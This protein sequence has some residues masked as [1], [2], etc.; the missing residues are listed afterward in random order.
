MVKG[1]VERGGSSRWEAAPS[2]GNSNS[3]PTD[4]ASVG[5]G[6]GKEKNFPR[7]WFPFTDGR[8]ENDN[9]SQNRWADPVLSFPEGDFHRGGQEKGAFYFKP[10]TTCPK[11]R[12]A[13]SSLGGAHLEETTKAQSS[14]TS[15]LLSKPVVVIAG[16]KNEVRD[17]KRFFVRKAKGKNF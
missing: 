2:M 13:D 16:P 9:L 15:S 6:S 12:Q 3:S 14:G 1:E 7:G 17:S 5:N 11:Q 8:R 4:G 10:E